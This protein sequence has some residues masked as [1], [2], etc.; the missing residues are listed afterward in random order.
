M[1]SEEVK[2]TYA[3]DEKAKRILVE[4]IDAITQIGNKSRDDVKQMILG[5]ADDIIHGKELPPEYQPFSTL[6]HF[7]EKGKYAIFW[8]SLIGALKSEAIAERK[9]KPMEFVGHI[10][11]FTPEGTP[12]P[13]NGSVE[14]SYTYLLYGSLKDMNGQVYP[15]ALTIGIQSGEFSKLPDL[16][17]GD[18][19]TVKVRASMRRNGAERKEDWLIE[20]S[21]GTFYLVSLLNTPHKTGEK[22][23]IIDIADTIM[24]NYNPAEI[25]NIATLLSEGSGIHPYIFEGTIVDNPIRAVSSKESRFPWG[26]YTII[27]ES[28]TAFEGDIGLPIMSPPW[29]VRYGEKSRVLSVVMLRRDERSGRKISA[30]GYGCIPIF[31]T[32]HLEPFSYENELKK[33]NAR[34]STATT[35]QSTDEDAL[36]EDDDDDE[37]DEDEVVIPPEKPPSAEDKMSNATE[38]E[39]DGEDEL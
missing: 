4:G 7:Y 3:S 35:S 22:R 29:M 25:Q 37:D 33:V 10:V 20:N 16:S 30:N 18:K 19:I 21:C 15:D 5:I 24:D 11:D 32:S 13:R 34:S 6:K 27:D 9:I 31:V 36:L 38:E 14:Y 2:K 23:D 12:R 17:I 26:R 8:S 1:V 28:V 39:D